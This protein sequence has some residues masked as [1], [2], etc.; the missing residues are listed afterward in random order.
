MNLTKT[1]IE[2]A[3]NVTCEKCNGQIMKNV[4]VVKSISGLLM[5]DG[6]DTYVPVP[7]FACDSCGHV[8]EAFANDLGLTSKLIK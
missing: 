6:K 1:Q 3:K 2:S 8:N 7:F 5:P 4:F